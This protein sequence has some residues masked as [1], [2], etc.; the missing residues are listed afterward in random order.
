MI[1]PPAPAAQFL[2]DAFETYA[3]KATASYKE[4]QALAD[5]SARWFWDKLTLVE[6]VALNRARM[7][8]LGE[9]KN[10]KLQREFDAVCKQIRVRLFKKKGER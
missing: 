10:A 8:A 9:P 4:A 3:K 7:D 2:R 6:R 1:I 5:N